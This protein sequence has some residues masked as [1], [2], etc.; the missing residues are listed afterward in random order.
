MYVGNPKESEYNQ[1]FL[2][3]STVCGMKVNT[4]VSTI[5]LYTS[6]NY[7]EDNFKGHYISINISNT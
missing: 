4:A 5:V 7:K 1:K 6:K 2:E 3:F